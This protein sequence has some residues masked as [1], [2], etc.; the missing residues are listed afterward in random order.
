MMHQ[1]LIGWDF[2][3]YLPV[4]LLPYMLLLMCNAFNRLAAACVPA[5]RMEFDDDF[6]TTSDMAARG[7]QLLQQELE[8]HVNGRP[9]GLSIAVQGEWVCFYVQSHV[10]RPGLLFLNAQGNGCREGRQPEGGRREAYGPVES[11]EV[12]GGCGGGGQAACC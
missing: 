3:T 1:P 6:E 12:E 8:N 5:R 11:L 10:W 7:L 4:A 9:L 2:T